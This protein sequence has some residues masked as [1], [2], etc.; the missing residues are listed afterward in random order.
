MAYHRPHLVLLP[1]LGT[2]HLMPLLGLAIRLAAKGFTVYLI[3]TSHQAS[4]AH[5]RLISSTP[6]IR[7]LKI[8]L[9]LDPNTTSNANPNVLVSL[10]AQ[11]QMIL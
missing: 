7:I 3:L 2:R 1:Y 5:N 10:V 8:D 6:N 4:I 11:S 9:K